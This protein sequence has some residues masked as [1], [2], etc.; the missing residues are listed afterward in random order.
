MNIGNFQLRKTGLKRF[1]WR[2]PYHIAL[3]VSWPHFLLAMIMFELIVNSLFAFLYLLQPATLANARP[4]SFA[5]AFFFSLETLA[6]VGYGEMSPAS[7]YGHVIASSEIICGVVFTAVL[8]GLI[9]GRFSRPRAKVLYAERPIVGM[10]DGIPALMIRIANG[11]TS[12]LADASVRLTALVME[13]SLEGERF[14]KPYDLTLKLSYFPLFALTWTL[15]HP[16]DGDSPLAACTPESLS[17]KSVRLFV[18]LTARDVSLSAQIHDIHGYDHSDIAFGM[19]YQDAL[20]YDAEGRTTADLKRLSL[21]EP[22]IP[23][24]SAATN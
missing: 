2:D 19:R 6:T 13:E 18:S 3:T 17:Q 9:F 22:L 16:L 21:I 12:L 8:T 23:G 11:R 4:G 14:R 20:S 15:I 24:P 10:H 5:D 7:T 1:D